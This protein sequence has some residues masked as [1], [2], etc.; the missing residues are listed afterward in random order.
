MSRE[1]PQLDPAVQDFVRAFGS[2]EPA[3][4]ATVREEAAGRPDGQMQISVEQGQ[5]FGVLVAAMGARRVLEVGTF[6]GYSSLVFADSV[7]PDGQV[8]TV[9]VDADIQAVARANAT[10]AGLADRIA[11]VTGDGVAALRAMTEARRGW[12]DLA[13]LDADKDRI[14]AYAEVTLDLVRPGGLV[15][16]DNLFRSGRVATEPDDPSVQAMHAL[17]RFAAERGLVRA[18]IPVSDGIGAFIA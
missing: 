5:F 9:D 17:S 11:Y 1:T 12:F 7:G 13:F 3:W 15:L 18:A 6:T 16:V 10:A 2:P 4:L 14:V 8:V